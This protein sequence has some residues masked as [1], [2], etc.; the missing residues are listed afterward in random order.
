MA[1]N[2]YQ[3]GFYSPYQ[4]NTYQ[5]PTQPSTFTPP[6]IHAEIIQVENADF[7]DKYPVGVG[8]SQMFMLRDDSIIFIKSALANGQTS[9]AI[10]PRKIT[11]PQKQSINMDNY[12]TR[13]EFEKRLERI[14]NNEFIRPIKQSEQ[15]FNS[16]IEK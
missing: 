8:Q 6:T 5:Q 15:Q 14:E 12:I 7:V 11:E 4:Y 13:E 10:Y 3:Y 16:T 1:Y 9:V 2:P